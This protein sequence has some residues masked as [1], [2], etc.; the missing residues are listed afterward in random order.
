LASVPADEQRAGDSTKL[1][2]QN[3]K[4]NNLSADIELSEYQRYIEK[5][6][7]TFKPIPSPTKNGRPS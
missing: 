1:R 3:S 4:K 5:N 7:Q 6:K 2:A